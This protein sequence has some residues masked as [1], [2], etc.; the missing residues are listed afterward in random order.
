MSDSWYALHVKAR[1]E[2]YVSNQLSTKGYETFFPTYIAK[3]KWSDRVKSLALP[4][5]PA[6][7]FCRFDV[8]SRLPILVTPGV[9][10][11]VG[12]GKLPTPIDQE[13]VAALRL[14]MNSGAAS[15]P[16]PYLAIGEKVQ[17]QIGPL[18][19]LIGI[20]ARPK[21]DDRLVVSVSLLMRSLSVEIGRN[22]VKR[23]ERER[24]EVS[25]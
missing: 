1:F 24:P 20:V 21:G 16:C 22:N 23:L 5:F 14:V 9:I 12:A 8:R 3:R 19:G 13:E 7:V 6:Y 11:I 4:V 15:E 10:A 25:K 18:K 17:V 2:Q